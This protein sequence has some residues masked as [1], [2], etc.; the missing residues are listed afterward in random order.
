MP[1]AKDKKIGPSENSTDELDLHG[2]TI[3]E[4]IPLVD[5]FLY[6]SFQTGL[7]RVWI[8]HGKGSGILRRAVRQHLSNHTLVRYCS[9]ANGSR[10]GIGATQV[11]ISD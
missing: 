2:L 7:R 11:E 1:Y 9:T 10:G 6:K 5:K 4:A 3:D 8:I